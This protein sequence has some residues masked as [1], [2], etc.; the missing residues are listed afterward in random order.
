MKVLQTIMKWEITKTSPEAP[1]VMAAL[2]NSVRKYTEDPQE[3]QAEAC[4]VLHDRLNSISILI[5]PPC[6]TVTIDALLSKAPRLKYVY[7]ADNNRERLDCWRQANSNYL[8]D[9]VKILELSDDDFISE[10]I[11]KENMEEHIVDMFL[12]RAAVYVPRRF[13]RLDEKLARFLEKNVLRIQQEACTSAAFRTTRSWHITMNQLIN[14]SYKKAYSMPYLKEKSRP[15]VVIVGAG[16]SLDS[17]VGTLKKYSD[18]AIII[19][20]DASL[21]TLLENDIKPDMVATLED[22]HLSW[23]FFSN[24]AD[25]KLPL[26]FPVNANH[27]LLRKY[28]GPVILTLT[29]NKLNWLDIFSDKLPAVAAGLCVGHYVFH[30]AEMLNPSEII[31]TGFDLSFKDNKFH[32]RSM[33]TPYHNDRPE[34]FTVVEVDGIDGGKV[35]TDVSM[36][37]YIKYFE[38]KISSC[39]CPVVHATEGGA[40]LRGSRIT[41]LEAALS[42]K[43]RK[44]DISFSLNNAFNS[45]DNEN[46]ISSLRSQFAGM[47]EKLKNELEKSDSMTV[48]DRRNPFKDYD[49]NAPVFQLI[50]SACNLLIISVFSELAQN[51]S[52]EKFEEYKASLKDLT[53]ELIDAA[54]FLFSLLNN[55]KVSS[56]AIGKLLF[57]LPENY[58]GNPILKMFEECEIISAETPLPEIWNIIS[59]KNISRLAVLDGN[60]LPDVWSVPDI[61]VYDIKTQFKPNMYERSLWI[62][63]YN[64]LCTDNSLLEQWKTFV[65]ADVKCNLL[66]DLCL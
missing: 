9:K 6:S 43:P 46:Y 38:E 29:E 27:M 13:M 52:D 19:A 35:K 25:R 59:E 8:S 7:I 58:S 3:P 16:P 2:D 31:M 42:G 57:L 37:F 20:T 11:L 54:G 49:T 65:P 48:A 50:C 40:F 28:E 44:P 55:K 39:K 61:E 24:C 4:S 41:T 33:A 36:S 53:V 5:I 12:G 26:V 34:S 1:A 66:K 17:T 56:P 10:R 62:P 63:G 15:S 23:R 32:A 30:I 64:L 21:K 51:Y 47:L 18:R 14:I 60:V 45:M 22:L